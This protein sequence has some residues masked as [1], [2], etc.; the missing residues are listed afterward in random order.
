MSNLVSICLEMV[1]VS[2]QDTCTTC[3][4]HTIHLGIIWT[5]PMEL[6]G[7]EAHVEAR[8]SWFGDNV[9]LTQYRCMICAKRTIVSEI[10]LDTPD[11]TPR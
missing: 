4:K 6:Q 2:V 7:D 9:I 11:G 10:I 1:L 5:L 8:F 3:A